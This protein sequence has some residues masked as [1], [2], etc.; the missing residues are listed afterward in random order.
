MTNIFLII[1]AII[2][3]LYRDI[4]SWSYTN[5]VIVNAGGF[6]I[7]YS[8]YYY[9]T[10]I[11][12]LLAPVFI[13]LK[14]NVIKFGNKIGINKTGIIYNII[15]F[16]INIIILTSTW[17]ITLLITFLLLEYVLNIKLLGLKSNIKEDQKKD[18]IISKTEAKINEPIIENSKKL[19][20]K[21]EKELLIGTQILKTEEESLDKLEIKEENIELFDMKKEAEYDNLIKKLF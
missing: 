19:E 12:T 1:D 6:T 13:M 15:N 4:Q 14:K 10:G 9:V 3:K 8:T 2:T 16:F 11:L 17:L 7:G 21:N 5:S 18:F 20:K